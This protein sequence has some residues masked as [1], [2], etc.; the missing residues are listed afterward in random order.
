MTGTMLYAQLFERLKIPF[1]ILEFPYHTNLIIKLNDR[2]Y[3]IEATDPRVGFVTSLDEIQDRI[4]YYRNVKEGESFHRI[5]GPEELVG[6]YYYNQAVKS[7]NRHSY[8]NASIM[9]K[10]ANALY[11]C[12]RIQRLYYQLELVAGKA[13]VQLSSY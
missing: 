3:M 12:E 13:F 9:L 7:Y 4:K 5:I 2:E 6:L 8:Y 11:S 10:K 1:D